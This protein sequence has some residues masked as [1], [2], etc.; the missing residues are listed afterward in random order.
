MSWFVYL[1]RCAD[2]TFYCGI[3]TDLERRTQ[4]HNQSSKAAKYTRSRQP[5]QLVYSESVA[6]RSEAARREYEIKRLSR[7]DKQR[8][9]CSDHFP[10]S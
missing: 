8:L 5:V 3:T 9:V 2:D 6:S 7:R 10:E 4:E 1:L